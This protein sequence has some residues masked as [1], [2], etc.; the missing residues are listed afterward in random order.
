LLDV[1][2]RENRF[3]SDQKVVDQAIGR[4]L[5]RLISMRRPGRARWKDYPRAED[6]V[7][8]ISDS[9]LALHVMHQ[10][11]V[12][13]PTVDRMWLQNLPPAPMGALDL[14]NSG[15]RVLLPDDNFFADGIRRYKLPWCLIATRDAY[16]SGSSE[17]QEAARQWVEKVLA[18]SSELERTVVVAP[19]AAAELLV[20]LRY[21]G[22]DGGVL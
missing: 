1:Y 9:G 11:G 6:G 21:L 17:E 3:P 15:H 13:D 12:V 7:E 16:A 5:Q 19:Y 22:G 20:S 14:E 8:S 18:N 2:R 4:G 10:L